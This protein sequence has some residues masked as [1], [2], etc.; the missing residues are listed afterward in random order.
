MTLANLLVVRVRAR[1]CL[2]VAACCWSC[3]VA[4]LLGAAA[5]TAASGPTFLLTNTRFS[6]TEN[7]ELALAGIVPRASSSKANPSALIEVTASAAHGSLSLPT[8]DGMFVHGMDPLARARATVVS[9][10]TISFSA[11]ESISQQAVAAL[12]YSP[13]ADWNGNDT[14][15][16]SVGTKARHGGPLTARANASIVVQVSSANSKPLLVASS[17]SV[18]EVVEDS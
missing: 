10:S 1:V 7:A 11:S 15:A 4:A 8:L 13:S 5:A 3:C 18:L 9:G 12:T 6:T 16:L 2:L 17:S 14:L